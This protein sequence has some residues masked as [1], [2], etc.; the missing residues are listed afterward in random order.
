[1]P[2]GRPRFFRGHS[3]TPKRTRDAEKSLREF[4]EQRMDCEGLEPFE[5]PLRVRLSFSRANRRRVDLDNLATLVLDALNTTAFV[6]DSQIVDLTA[7]KDHDATHP[8][9]VVEIE[10]V[11]P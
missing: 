7:T 8:R 4:A 5:G 6:D 1:M 2:K 9:T 3:V 10:E 11:L